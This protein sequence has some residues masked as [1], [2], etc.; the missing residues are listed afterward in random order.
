MSGCH[1]DGT[2]SSKELQVSQAL[3]RLLVP[4]QAFRSPL[5]YNGS[6]SILLSEETSKDLGP[7]AQ[8]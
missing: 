2:R 5:A 1:E 4:R 3:W 6:G 7:L 8:I